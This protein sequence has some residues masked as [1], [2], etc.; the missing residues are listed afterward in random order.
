METERWRDGEIG[1]RGDGEKL[2]C[3]E[4]SRKE[5]ARRGD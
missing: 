2:S 1:R 4:I 5:R 3:P